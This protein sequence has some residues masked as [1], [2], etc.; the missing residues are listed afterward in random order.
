MKGN[1]PVKLPYLALFALGTVP[2]FAQ[3]SDLVNALAKH[4]E[5]SQAFSAAVADAMPD[6]GY[7]F[8]ASPPEMTFGEMVNH[9]AAANG[10]YCSAALGTE[11][12]IGRP[13]DASKSAAT[14]NL[15]KAYDYCI[16]GLK[17]LTDADLMKTVGPA[18]RHQTAF[19]ALWGGF[20]HS[21]HHRAQ[22]EVYL[23]LKGIKP[24]DYKF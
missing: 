17:K 14:Q 4:W 6:D 18:E 23:R 2:V 16:S 7:S 19:E 15:Q 12:P 8:K 1:W 3:S 9:I 13:K 24:P 5:R 11:N 20:T 22:L 10:N 21:A